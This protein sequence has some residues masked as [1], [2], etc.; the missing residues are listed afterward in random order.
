MLSILAQIIFLLLKVKHN[1]HNMKEGTNF[2]CFT[3]EVLL[4]L[5]QDESVVIQLLK[6]S[7]QCKV[8]ED[9]PQDKKWNLS[10]MFVS[11]R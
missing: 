2:L 1:C 7:S 9:N 8:W 5:T 3:Q 11:Q 10:S 4:K 6:S